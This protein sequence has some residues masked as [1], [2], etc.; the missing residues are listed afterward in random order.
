MLERRDF[1]LATYND[2][3]GWGGALSSVLGLAE[4]FE[5]SGRSTR[6]LGVSRTGD[7]GGGDSDPG[8]VNLCPR[9]WERLWRIRSW[10]T[11][12]ALARCLRRL[13]PPTDG[14]I[15][16]S[17]FWAVAAKQ[18]WPDVPLVYL[19]P[20]LLA[21]C[22]PFTWPRRRPPTFWASVDFA[23]IRRLEQAALARAD[24]TLA[25]TE[26]GVAE[27]LEFTNGRCRRLERF[28]K[29]VPELVVCPTRRAEQR[30]ALALADDAFVLL[31]VGTLDSNKAFDAGIDALAR[32]A[33]SCHLILVGD[34]SERDRL[35]SRATRLGVS[36]RVRLVG[37]QSDLAPFYAAADVVISTSWYDTF[38]NAI[39]QAMRAGKA[40]IVPEHDP[41]RVYSGMAEV[42]R[43]FGGGY[44]YDRCLPESLPDRIGRLHADVKTRSAMGELG[45][46][47]VERCFDWHWCVERI[48]GLCGVSV[49]TSVMSAQRDMEQLSSATIR[50]RGI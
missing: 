47:V 29:G 7:D 4:A 5:R 37:A 35:K 46:S 45:R 12:G 31:G 13:N 30:R 41:P 27:I 1:Y 24:L 40:V 21:N 22:L 42:L 33:E 9:V 3:H 28:Y 15:A 44:C 17:P 16:A 25:P 50:P 34:G 48:A 43:Q 2:A 19:F 18:A 20:C 49:A 39:T 26:Q 38:P 23:G 32:T 8:R 11:P 14:F 6:V 36:G 10:L